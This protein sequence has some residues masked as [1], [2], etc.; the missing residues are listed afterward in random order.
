M[1]HS[2]AR[3]FHYGWVRTPEAMREKTFF[4][5]QLYHGKPSDEDAQAGIPHTGNNYRYKRFW[6][7]RPYKGDHPKYMAQRISQKGWH[8]D[9]EQSPFVFS[10]RDMKKIVLDLFERLT[11]IRLFEYR[12]Y[13]QIK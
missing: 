12:S 13:R 4:M 10:W 3:I 9:L 1:I 11:G 8:W 7:L 2:G 6:G 5:D